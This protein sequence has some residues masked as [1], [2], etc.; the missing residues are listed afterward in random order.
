MAPT[1]QPNEHDGT[2]Q[3]EIARLRAE[4]AR[5]RRE[6]EEAQDAAGARSAGRGSRR[7]RWI[8]AV[9]LAVLTAALV[10]VAVPALFL[11][12]ALLDTDRYLATVAP[13]AA[14]PA[15]QAEI[16]DQVTDQISGLVDV[17]GI[18]RDALTELTRSTPRLA[19]VIT[20][21]APV[22]AERAR[23][24]THD[25]VSRFVAS[26]RFEDLW[27]QLNRASHEAMVRYVGGETGGVV[28]IDDAGTVTI[29]SQEIIAR[30]KDRLVAAGLG[31][32][33]RIPDVDTRITLFQSPE[34]VRAKEAINLLDRV[35]P[36]VAWLAVAGAV[37]AVAV[38]PRG[39][40]LRAVGSVGLGLAVA[41]ALLAL[42]L[43]VGRGL[44]LDGL[45]PEGLSPSAAE[46]LVDAFLVPL[47]A[48]VRALFVAGLLIAVAAFLF[49]RSATAGLVR[50]GLSRSRDGVARLLAGTEDRPWRLWLT[51]Y[52]RIIQAALVGSAALVLIFW[53]QPTPAV[54]LWT[55][56]A[57]GVAILAVE[58]LGRPASL[59]ARDPEPASGQPGS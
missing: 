6:R 24:M 52:R 55:A 27:V 50:Q 56:A 54:A 51:R 49:G 35:A 33:A 16:T 18:T 57:T 29:S 1:D 14:D 48:I 2:R 37:A 32:A 13:L 3:D 23:S 38:A 8:A 39:L 9:L 25:A 42:A 44:Y 26:P 22:A 41:M 45:S 53:Q 15:I 59:R 17:E 30:V 4:V 36:L 46:S 28:G 12:A 10:F 40:R 5:L 43:A 31:I 7:T 47:R 20:S 19:P 58:L 21:L 11:R 34:L